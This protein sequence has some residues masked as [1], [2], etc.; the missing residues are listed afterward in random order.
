VHP[1]TGKEVF[2]DSELPEDM[3]E[4]LGELRKEGEGN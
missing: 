3:S 2:F 4:V 1:A